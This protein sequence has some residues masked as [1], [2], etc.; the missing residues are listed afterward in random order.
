MHSYLSGRKFWCPNINWNIINSQCACVC[1]LIL[2]KIDPNSAWFQ[3][4]GQD[5]ILKILKM[6]L[7]IRLTMSYTCM[8]PKF[9]RQTPKTAPTT[10][11]TVFYAKFGQQNCQIS[12]LCSNVWQKCNVKIICNFIGQSFDNYSYLHGLQAPEVNA[13]MCMHNVLANW[14]AKT[15]PIGPKWKRI[16][17]GFKTKNY[18]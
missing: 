10:A 12:C 9:S 16:S 14:V 2:P 3:K 4:F 8:A 15:N 6:L 13:K 7:R 11:K 17:L 1:V 5:V 18:S